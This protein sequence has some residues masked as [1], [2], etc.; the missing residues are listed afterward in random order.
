MWGPL[1]TAS[2]L[3]AGW[4]RPVPI[5]YLIPAAAL[6]FGA[7]I[8]C[9]TEGSRAIDRFRERYQKLTVTYDRGVPSCRAD[10]T[11]TDNSHSV[12]FR[13]KVEN[14]TTRK[15][16]DCEGWLVSTDRFP[17][18]SPTKLFWIVGPEV[19]SVDLIKEIPQFL[20]ICRI[21]DDNR[22]IMATEHEAWPVDSLERVSARTI[23]F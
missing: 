22:V 1:L 18:I 2:V 14:T 7:V 13:L 8:W 15:L 19:F 23:R 4:L 6:T 3:I 10:V 12:C 5:S 20:Q 21:K 9:F 11:F 17:H 16:H